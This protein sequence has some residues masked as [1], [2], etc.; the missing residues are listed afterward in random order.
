MN[1]SDFRLRR[2]GD[3]GRKHTL[4]YGYVLP[5][6]PATR[7]LLRHPGHS[8]N[9]RSILRLPGSNLSSP[10]IKPS[11]ADA[12][13]RLDC[14][15][16]P[17]SWST[18]YLPTCRYSLLHPYFCLSLRTPA[19]THNNLSATRGARLSRSPEVL[20]PHLASSGP[21]DQRDRATGVSYQP[22]LFSQCHLYPL[23]HSSIIE[24]ARRFS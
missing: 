19:Q 11:Q 24:E 14:E 2:R 3:T 6:A 21:V 7:R 10:S 5:D 8:V 15:N 18:A 16:A 12:P 17:A 9:H 23:C 1:A 20:A 22:L 4:G 13:H